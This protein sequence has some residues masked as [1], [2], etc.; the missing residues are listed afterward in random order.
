MYVKKRLRISQPLTEWGYRTD[1]IVESGGGRTV[2][3]Y[4]KF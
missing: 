2:P 3:C 1:A 4:T